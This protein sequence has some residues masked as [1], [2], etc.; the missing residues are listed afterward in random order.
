MRVLTTSFPVSKDNSVDSIL[1]CCINW[2]RTNPHT[3]IDKNIP[4]DIDFTVGLTSFMSDSEVI[5]VDKISKEN[6]IGYFKSEVDINS[7]IWTSICIISKNFQNET[8]IT[9]TVDYNTDS[10]S[11][12]PPNVTKPYVYKNFLKHLSPA[13]DHIFP[14]NGQPIY[15]T[16]TIQDKEIIGKILNN[17]LETHLPIIYISKDINN[18]FLV[19]PHKLALL[20]YGMAHVLVEPRPNFINECNNHFYKPYGGAIACFDKMQ[21]STWIFLPQDTMSNNDKNISIGRIFQRLRMFLLSKK[22]QYIY[23]Y[24]YYKDILFDCKLSKTCDSKNSFSKESFDVLLKEIKEK[25]AELAKK[26]TEIQQLIAENLNKEACENAILTFGKEKDLY[27]GEILDTVLDA[28]EQ[29]SSGLNKTTRR[30]HIL[31]DIIASNPKKEV[32]SENWTV[33]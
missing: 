28:I 19:D 29:A 25:K 7:E 6:T 21:N 23:T 9:F 1:E 27:S 22:T 11:F 13:I 30:K 18:K 32:G 8:F 5:E 2:R 26:D 10:V 12:V 15:L 4:T 16:D 24:E 33:S 31:A 20:T 3:D 17:N 14:I